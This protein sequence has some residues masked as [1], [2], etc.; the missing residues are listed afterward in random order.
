MTPAPEDRYTFGPASQPP[1]RASDADRHATVHTLQEAMARGL[2]TLDEG[3]ERMQAAYS[4]RYLTDLTRLTADLPAAPP[5]APVAPGWSAI[6]TM[7]GQQFRLSANALPLGPLRGNRVALG[8]VAVILFMAFVFLLAHG[9][10]EGGG[11]DHFRE[12]DQR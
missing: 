1:M 11:H 10:A 12:F 2:L 4:S 8:V 6:A 3:D 7:V 9:F 5:S